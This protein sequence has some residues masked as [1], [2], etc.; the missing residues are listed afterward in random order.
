MPQIDIN[1][2]APTLLLGIRLGRAHDVAPFVG[3]VSIPW[4][5]S[6]A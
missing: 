5:V 1:T 6:Q 4:K 2:L 3:S